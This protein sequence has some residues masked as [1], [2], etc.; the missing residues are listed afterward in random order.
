[1]RRP[2]SD[3]DPERSSPLPETSKVRERLVRLSHR[4]ADET[5]ISH[6]SQSEVAACLLTVVL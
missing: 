6:R 3:R 5:S 1:V 4:T 2:S